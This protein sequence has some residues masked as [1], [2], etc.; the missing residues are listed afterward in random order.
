MPLFAPPIWIGV[1]AIGLVVLALLMGRAALR[2]GAD[3]SRQRRE[4]LDTV[5]AWPAEASRVLTRPERKGLEI[6]RRALP[7]HLVLA[8]VPLARFLRVPRRHSYTEWM[9]RVGFVNADL[10]ICDQG[11]KVLAVI[12]IRPLQESERAKRRHERIGQVLRGAGIHV[13]TW[14]EDELPSPSDLRSQLLPLIE[15]HETVSQPVNSKPLP[16]IPVAEIEEILAD[17][18]AAAAQDAAMEPVPSTLFDDLEP[19]AVN[20]KGR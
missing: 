3:A 8:Q 10:L 1:A 18:D 20:S 14:R 11:S 4:A 5:M 9:Q 16:L 7:D 6:A 13:I 17:G 19:I 15:P 2:G 12:D